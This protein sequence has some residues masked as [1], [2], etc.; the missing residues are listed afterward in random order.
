MRA[1]APLTVSSEG[2]SAKVKR[3]SVFRH[4]DG[5]TISD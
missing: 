3:V 2:E 5:S 4:A 1:K